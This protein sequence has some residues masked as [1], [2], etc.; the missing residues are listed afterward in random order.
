[1]SSD[2]PDECKD[3]EHLLLSRGA[4]LYIQD[5]MQR[6][7][8][9]YVFAKTRGVPLSCGIKADPVETYSTFASAMQY[10]GLD[11]VDVRGCSPLHYAAACGG[12]VSCMLLLQK[13][14]DVN[15]LD[16]AGNTPLSLAVQNKHDSVTLTL[17]Q[18]GGD[19]NKK[20]V[21]NSNL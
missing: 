2:N 12:V 9:H 11:S 14:C 21:T 3:V 17:M 4:D 8:L 10:K 7:P 13:G 5:N 16:K 18:K 20:V 6:L 1:M 15:R 19:I